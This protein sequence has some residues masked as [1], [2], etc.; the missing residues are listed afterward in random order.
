MKRIILSVIFSITFL[1]SFSQSN[2]WI[3]IFSPSLPNVKINSFDLIETY[4]NGYIIAAVQTNPS[5]TIFRWGWLI[6]TDINGNKIWEKKIG[7]GDKVVS[8]TEMTQ[9]PD[10]GFLLSGSTDLM[11][12]SYGDAFFMKLDACGNKEWCNVIHNY[13]N[14]NPYDYG[15][16]I[17]PIP[18][19]DAYIGLIT[20]WGI[21]LPPDSIQ[22]IW[23][24]KL[25]NLGHAVWIKNIFD[26]VQPSTFNEMPY[27]MFISAE[28]NLIIYG[29]IAY[30]EGGYIKPFIAS[31][32][33]D[34][35]ENWWAIVAM[36]EDFA[37]IAYN[38][39]E[40][41]S[42]NIYATGWSADYDF[43]NIRYPGIYKL[44]TNG[45]IIYAKH[46]I[47]STEQ[48]NTFCLNIV[49]NSTI[50]VAA[51]MKY[52][53]QLPY[54]TIIRIDTG[55][56]FLLEKQIMQS[57]FGFTNSI[58]TFD[59]KFLFV[60]PFEDG[61]YT[62][63][64]LH[65]FNSDL[66]YDSIYNQPFEYDY[67]CNEL[68]IVSDTIGIDDCDIWTSL[69]DEIEFTQLQNLVVYPNPAREKI[70][71]K[72]PWATAVEQPFGPLTSRH[73]NL[74]YFQNSVLRIYDVFG[75]MSMEIPLKDQQE[76]EL[77]I[78]ISAFPQG[79]YLINLYENNRKMASG[80]FVKN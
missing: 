43:P 75:K 48:V 30:G 17:Y 66:E 10:G 52:P 23:L 79:I 11:E 74:Q 18:N 64:H 25:N 60:G 6:K 22:G 76:N 27:G 37:G 56:N 72:L 29:F 50:D 70:N 33:F 26:Q 51:A 1:V 54:N 16:A 63:I 59:D 15:S 61:N 2:D 9:T 3:R 7:N 65:K 13:N 35:T 55:G 69:P 77:N 21:L 12:G 36:D 31:A 38:A 45:N 42:G 44:D 34:G 46:I 58:R 53:N 67:M 19:E 8:F 4:D 78:N 20:N 14:D 80:K 40:D 32:N 5:S 24:I 49:N 57:D 71:V 39:I 62:R 28:G 68:P 47:D 73:Y 41:S